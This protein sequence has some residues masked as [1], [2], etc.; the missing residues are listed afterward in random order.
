MSD[1]IFIKKVKDVIRRSEKY[2]CPKFSKFLDEHEQA[3]I[4]KEG[5]TEGVLF[6]GYPNAERKLFG[7]FPDWQEPEI[8][9][10]PISA[11]KIT[12]KYDK[13]LNHRHYLG[14]V[15]S[16][17]IE[18]DKIGDILPDE[19]GAVIFVLEDIADFIKDNINKIAG[20]GVNITV[21]AG[22]DLKVPEKRFQLIE[23]IS[24]SM[25]LDAVLGAVLKI[26][27]KDAK[28]LSVS[29]NVSV[30]HME[31]KGEAVKLKEGDLLSVRGFGRV[32]IV[33]IGDKTRSD[34]V[35]ITVKKYI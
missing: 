25:R 20:C 27:R 10:F 11:L 13:D 21:E 15:L 12:K 33:E 5:I 29:G 1:D 8:S 28:E 4:L 23:T 34:R 2:H 26:S 16:L 30:N 14:T 18:R 19:D 22:G 9:E 6:G 32:E 17:G 35:H 7:V 3:V 24:A 31:A